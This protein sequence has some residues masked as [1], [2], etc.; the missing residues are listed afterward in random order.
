MNQEEMIA[1]LQTM[2]D[3]KRFLHTL[4]VRE[5]ALELAALY[6]VNQEQAA[7]AALLHDCAK[8]LPF[9]I[10]FE[11][12]QKAGLLL[13][14]IDYK[15]PQLLHGPVGAIIAHRDFGVADEAIL[16]SIRVHTL[17]S[18][19]MSN[20][21]KIIYIADMIEP[22]RKYQSVCELRELANLNLD[23]AILACFD[24]S[25]HY[26]ISSGFLIHPQTVDA[27]NFLIWSKKE[28]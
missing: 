12:A 14:D 5:T 4:G 6:Q 16:Q 3:Q 20:L 13:K 8:N 2:L 18:I 10:L 24:A 23:K 28:N 1:K 17:G 25:L 7:I 9:V 27:R 22:S 11:E 15:V 19:N 26:V 21:D